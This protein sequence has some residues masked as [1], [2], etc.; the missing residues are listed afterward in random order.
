MWADRNSELM[1]KLRGVWLNY[2]KHCP[3]LHK[4]HALSPFTSE[5]STTDYS[6][7]EVAQP[8]NIHPLPKNQSRNTSSDELTTNRTVNNDFKNSPYYEDSCKNNE[9]PFNKDV[10]YRRNERKQYFNVNNFDTNLTKGLMSTQRNF[11]C[12]KYS[13]YA[14]DFSSD[15]SQNHKKAYCESTSNKASTS[16][17]YGC[18]GS[19]LTSNRD[20]MLNRD[21]T[22]NKN[23]ISNR[24]VMSTS[25][26]LST[27]D[28]LSKFSSDVVSRDCSFACDNTDNN[29]GS[30]Y[31]TL[32]T[33][34]TSSDVET[35][36]EK[37]A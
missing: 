7:T 21:A 5:P 35:Q 15:I 4:T 32:E 29:D 37:V 25:D 17:Q 26:H 11:N 31:H 12:G 24:D 28:D 9:T 14:S 18:S 2:K 8:T 34:D 1:R 30:L 10:N 3:T 20:V 6:S 22:S 33:S 27:G 19:D 13:Y 23:I 36:Y 16:K